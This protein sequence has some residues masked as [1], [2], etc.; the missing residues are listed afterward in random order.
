[1]SN[2]DEAEARAALS[3]VLDLAQ[4]STVGGRTIDEITERLLNQ[5]AEARAY[6]LPTGTVQLVNNYL[7]IAGRPKTAIDK[8][9]KLTKQAKLDISS[10]LGAFEKRVELIATAGISPGKLIFDADFGRNMEYYTG[11]VFELTVPE[12]GDNAQ[13]AGGGRYDTLLRDL[14]APKDIPAVGC[15]I[16]TERLLAAVSESDRT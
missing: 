8:I 15:M 1:M 2:L 7:K 10:A 3:D 6:A 9:R 14:G 12:L 11:F 5:A 13:I 4:I 16:R